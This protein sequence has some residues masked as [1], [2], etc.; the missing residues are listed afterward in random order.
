MGT[1][2]VDDGTDFVFPGRTSARQ[3]YW[4]RIRLEPDQ[5]VAEASVDGEYWDLLHG[6]PRDRYPGDPVGVRVGKTGP[7]GRAEDFSE[8]AS[9]GACALGELRVYGAQAP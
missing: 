9:P 3:S 7:G 6:Y 2:G 4:L 8:M 5:V 1:F